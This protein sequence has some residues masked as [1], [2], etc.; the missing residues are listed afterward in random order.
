M[1][2]MN[3]QIDE[4]MLD[5]IEERSIDNV[6]ANVKSKRKRVQTGY[7]K[8]S[9]IAALLLV[10]ISIPYLAKINDAL[11]ELSIDQQELSM[12]SVLAANLLTEQLSLDSDYTLMFLAD[13]VYEI[14]NELDHVNLYFDKFKS[15]MNDESLTT[16]LNLKES[17]MSGYQYRLDFEAYNLNYQLHFNFNDGDINGLLKSDNE[18]FTINGA[19][20]QQGDNSS[21]SIKAQNG[22]NYIEIIRDEKNEGSES[23]LELRINERIN[24]RF[25]NKEVV[26]KTE[27][28]EKVITVT[29]N[30]NSYKIK[31]QINEEYQYRLEYHFN[32][33]D[34][35][36]EIN[37][38]IDNE[39]NQS[40]SYKITENGK[41]KL[42]IKGKPETSNNSNNNGRNGH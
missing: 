17:T 18:E 4:N 27:E 30:G 35:V 15:F 8:L 31:S 32:G 40:Y 36:L 41:S 26:I 23:K 2:K 3:R 10:I 24:S 7:R 1:N 21:F 13:D 33:V 12:A 19:F 28:S 22:S 9:M 20:V 6:L 34:G 38:T 29:D 11:P 25:T 37:E 16:S 5:I 39:G 14:D 42:I